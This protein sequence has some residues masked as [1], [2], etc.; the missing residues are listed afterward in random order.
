VATDKYDQVKIALADLVFE[1][2]KHA[3]AE[4]NRGNTMAAAHSPLEDTLI[5]LVPISD[6]EAT[7]RVSGQGKPR[8]F[9]IKV[10]SQ[11]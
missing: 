6:L 3:F 1:S 2:A 9:S 5:E 7:V 8:Y 11:H 4:S 10:H